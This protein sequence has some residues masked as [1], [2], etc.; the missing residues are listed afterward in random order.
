[1]ICC[2]L[3]SRNVFEFSWSA[4]DVV[5]DGLLAESVTTAGMP[6][7]KYRLERHVLFTFFLLPLLFVSF[8]QA[9]ESRLTDA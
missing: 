3:R 1:M 7:E 8:L 5:Q 6:R 2:S 9:Y 4:W